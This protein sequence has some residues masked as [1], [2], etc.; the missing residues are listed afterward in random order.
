MLCSVYHESWI[1]NG[2][3]WNANPLHFTLFGF[4]VMRIYDWTST[5]WTDQVTWATFIYYTTKAGTVLFVGAAIRHSSSKQMQWA[6]SSSFCH[7]GSRLDG[8]AYCVLKEIL[9][10]IIVYCRICVLYFHLFYLKSPPYHLGLS[11]HIS[12]A[13]LNFYSSSSSIFVFLFML[14]WFCR[15]IKGREK[16][17]IRCR[18]LAYSC[19]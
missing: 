4:R 5:C 6:Q 10:Y 7:V 9:M 11:T 2:W 18:H 8:L 15:V 17:K 1:K 3:M 12:E 19:R 14:Y 13:L 16:V